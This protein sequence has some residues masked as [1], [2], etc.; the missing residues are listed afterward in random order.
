MHITSYVYSYNKCRYTLYI[1]VNI[2]KRS[3]IALL[4]V[5]K[6]VNDDTILKYNFK[7]CFNKTF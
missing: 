6:R 4:L 1:N 2:S 7:V 5:F 3:V